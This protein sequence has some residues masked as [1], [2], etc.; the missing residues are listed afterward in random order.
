MPKKEDSFFIR[1]TVTTN[2]TT[3]TQEA[4]DLGAFVDALGM[5]ILKVHNVSVQYQNQSNTVLPIMPATQSTSK[6]S[7]QLT[8]QS[9][10][11]IIN[12]GERTVFGSGH[13]TV[14]NTASTSYAPTIVYETEDVNAQDWMNGYAIAVDQVDLGVDNSATLLSSQECDVTVLLECTVERLNKESALALALSQQ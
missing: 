3:F 13:L 2:G 8:T 5:S 1:H 10:S 11:A 12:L 6:I 7:W 9:Q 14:G 4:I